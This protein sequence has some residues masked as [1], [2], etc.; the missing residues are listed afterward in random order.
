MGRAESE[1]AVVEDVKK[2]EQDTL[3]T[4]K[5]KDRR[6]V[7]T[8]EIMAY[9]EPTYIAVLS[10]LVPILSASA[11]PLF[12]L[13]F[14]KML[15]VIMQP[16]KDN[17]YD[18]LN[19]NTLYFFGVC[20]LMASSGAISKLVFTTGGENCSYNIRKKVFEEI[21]HKQISWF[22]SQET[23]PG[24]LSNVLSEMMAKINGMTTESIAVILEA[25]LTILCSVVISCIYS[26]R[27]ALV[28]LAVSPMQVIGTFAMGKLQWRRNEEEDAY[29]KS[30]ALLSEIIMNYRT[31]VGFGDKNIDQIMAKYHTHLYL[32]N[33]AAVRKAHISGF[34]FGYSQYAKLGMIGI[35]FYL[36]TEIMYKYDLDQLD[37]YTAVYVIFIGAV[38]TGFSL[39][40]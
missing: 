23:S 5:E 19:L 36:A 10:M 33:R 39:S 31:I 6:E 13:V 30:N 11:F 34:F 17:F 1:A 24:V 37:V 16:D 29:K 21:L 4:I 20:L 18:Q 27:V 35:V 7:S 9:Y 25:V 38:G 28:T 3:K 14:T 40:Q 2:Q 22:D 32:P 26:W 12:G 8:S 15:F